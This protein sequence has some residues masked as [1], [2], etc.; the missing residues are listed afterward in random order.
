MK[1][2]P[3]T[4]HHTFN[5]STLNSIFHPI[6]KGAHV[7]TKNETHSPLP[8]L[9][10]PSQGSQHFVQPV[11]RKSRESGRTLT[12]IL[13]QRREQVDQLGTFPSRVRE[14]IGREN[15]TSRPTTVPVTFSIFGEAVE[16]TSEGESEGKRVSLLAR[17]DKLG[18]RT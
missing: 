13:S 7:K 15:T 5:H 18:E 1:T 12:R 14:R 4:V 10:K 9:S 3:C 17:E 2:R 16:G 6:H 11:K 8:P